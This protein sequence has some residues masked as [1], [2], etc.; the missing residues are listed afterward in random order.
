MRR[1]KPKPERKRPLLRLWL[2]SRRAFA[3][4]DPLLNQ[5]IAPKAGARSDA[6]ALSAAARASPQSDAAQR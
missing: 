3:D 1:P 6:E 5:G 2:S 4:S